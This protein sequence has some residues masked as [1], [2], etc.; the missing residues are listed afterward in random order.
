MKRHGLVLVIFLALAGTSCN[1]PAQTAA[2]TPRAS[3]IKVETKSGGP[4][5][6]TT[7]KAEFQVLPSGAVQAYLLKN[8]GK[9]TLD[10]ASH[11]SPHISQ[12]GKT[13]H[14]TFDLDHATVTEASGSSCG[15]SPRLLPNR[16]QT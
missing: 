16:S 12:D 4:I 13:I 1:K 14:F 2:P 11:D 9:L 5:V 7:S 15:T 6:L 8:G 3:A 10:A